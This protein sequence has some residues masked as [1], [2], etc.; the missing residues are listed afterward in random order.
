M[1]LVMDVAVVAVVVAVR[2]HL[3]P[4]LV[5]Q[6][7]VAHKRGTYRRL[8]H[9]NMVI[10]VTAVDDTMG[11]VDVPPHLPHLQMPMPQGMLRR[12]SA[13]W[14]RLKLA[15]LRLRSSI[16]HGNR[17]TFVFIQYSLPIYTMF[18]Y[19]YFPHRLVLVKPEYFPLLPC[20]GY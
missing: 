3:L 19:E 2:L 16:E 11:A 17:P 13:T 14:R 6:M 1:D 8:K 4:R 15:V 5:L 12:K 9:V 7:T 20:H 10:I 18:K